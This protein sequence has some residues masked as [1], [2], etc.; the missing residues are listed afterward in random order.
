MHP[1]TRAF[2][3]ALGG[4]QAFVGLFD[5]LP[6]AYCY[7]KDL[8][9]RFMLANQAQLALLGAGTLDEVIGKRDADFF[10]ADIADLYVAEDQEAFAGRSI[11]NKRWMVPDRSGRMCWYLSSKVP[12]CGANGNI[13][14]LCG[15]LRDLHSADGEVQ[16]YGGLA[17]AIAHINTHYRRPIM[18]GELAA[19]VGLSVSQ[20][21]RKF[22][23]FTGLS[24]ADYVTAVRVNAAKAQL[25]HGDRTVADIA[26]YLGFYDQ[27]HFSRLFGKAT[28]QSPSR[29]RREGRATES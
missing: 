13:I 7:A 18:A 22:K 20:F 19:R 21:N 26:E 15:L 8:Q 25:L 12:L 28:G 29:F 1:L 23:A 11:L 17:P 27:S 3:A 24:P 14:G 10:D 9:S 4:P 16:A 2:T 6:G 5:T